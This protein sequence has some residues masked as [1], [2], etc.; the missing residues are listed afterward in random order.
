[1][2]IDAVDGKTMRRVVQDQ[3]CQLEGRTDVM[4]RNVRSSA[5]VEVRRQKGLRAD[6]MVANMVTMSQGLHGAS[7]WVPVMFLMYAHSFPPVLLII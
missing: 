5:F 4:I 7:E 2:C 3:C 1:M 6:G